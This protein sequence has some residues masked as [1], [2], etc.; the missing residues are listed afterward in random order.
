MPN[1]YE[2][3]I[4][5]LR[6]QLAAANRAYYENDDPVMS[7]RAYDEA[8]AELARLE[9]E[10]PE[11][12]DPSSPTVRVGGKAVLKTGQVAHANPL[13]SLLDVFD[14]DEAMAWTNSPGVS[15][16]WS[17]ESK[18]DGLSC[19][20]EYRNGKLYKAATRGDGRVGEDVTANAM[21]IKNIQKEIPG[22]DRVTVRVEVYM[23]VKVFEALNAELEAAG[24]KLLKNPRNAAAGALR[25]ND[26]S[27]T[28]RR[29]LR[30]A[31]FAILDAG[32]EDTG[33]T[34]SERLAWLS[35]HGF[36]IAVAHKCGTQ[37]EVQA[38]I[39]AIDADRWSYSFAIDGAAIKIDSLDVQMA[40]G[41][42][43]KYPRWAVAFKYPPEQK[44]T[45]L[46]DIVLQVGRTGVAT[47]V[48]VFD[49]VQLAGTTVTRATL[50]NQSFMD[51]I[52]GGI[53]VGDVI[54]VHKSGEI[55]PEVLSVDR[56]GRPEGVGNY[57]MTTCPS[58][59]SRLVLAAD[60]DGNGTRMVC[61]NPACPAILPRVLEY[62]CSKHVMDIDGFGPKLLNA[63]VAAG[64]VQSPV[65]LYKL[66]ED[67]LAGIP[68]AGPVRAPRLLK[69]VDL[70]RSRG[71][72]RVVAG[73]GIPGV[74]RHVGKALAKKY[75]SVIE[76]MAGAVA[77]E[78]V[79]L[80]GIGGITARDIAEWAKQPTSTA[81]LNGL[82]DVGVSLESNDWSPD[83]AAP[84]PF[85]GL[86]FVIT[87]TLPGMGREEAKSKLE[88]MGAKVS[89][90][91]S[92]KTSYLVAGEAAGSKYDKAMSL[93][94]PVLSPAQMAK[95]LSTGRLPS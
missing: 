12:A 89:G 35:A 60:E 15:G 25:T 3:K 1:D 14:M 47:P 71:M 76:A 6:Q 52:L 55:I 9:A 45:V 30:A 64:L 50:H 68:E 86:T 94:V 24:K 39:E 57:K 17:V 11:L 48:A 84:K 81:F 26:P 83:G 70:S 67:Q 79:E 37:G 4:R 87:G 92:R 36:E 90:S 58:C 21:A 31:A 75:P 72:E 23:P 38:A 40:L 77:G 73:L 63:L 32:T 2:A 82:M 65:D 74:G 56:S 95:A 10:H 78:L 53:A 29:G 85:D 27:E 80:E 61:A 18:I 8:M 44:A 20:L 33:S 88:A 91:V 34:Q 54:V 43:E 5:A 42:N 41:E 16:P 93:G 46:R 59:G 13:L 66:T 51:V 49:P 19:S 28:A 7:D 69:A 62:W 22:V